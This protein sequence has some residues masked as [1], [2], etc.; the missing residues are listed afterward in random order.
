MSR[1]NERG[2]LKKPPRPP[3]TSRNRAEKPEDS[4]EDEDEKETLLAFSYL[5]VP[6]LFLG[7]EG[8]KEREQVIDALT[9]DASSYCNSHQTEQGG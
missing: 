8:E 4:C 9:R 3:A 5:F 7:M 2:A 6:L 1:K